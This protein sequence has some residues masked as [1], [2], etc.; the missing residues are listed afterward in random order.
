MFEEH[1]DDVSKLD[2][3]IW[4]KISG[5]M[6]TDRKTLVLLVLFVIMLGILDTVYPLLNKYALDTF[7]VTNPDFSKYPL[8]IVL[9]VSDDV[10]LNNSINAKI[11]IF[12]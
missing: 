1:D 8:Y 2:L 9:Y 10:Y 4:K 11:G 3:Q 12:L 5:I 6:F 7:F